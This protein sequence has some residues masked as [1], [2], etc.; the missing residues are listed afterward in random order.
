MESYRVTK[1]YVP[2]SGMSVAFR[3][4]R[5]DSHCKFIHG[6]ALGIEITFECRTLD[7]RNWV[8]DFGGLKEI[9]AWIQENFDHKTLVARDDPEYQW[10]EE[11][12]RRG[13]LDMVAV[14]KIGCEG[15]A[16]MIGTKVE[17]WLD[18]TPHRKRVW[19][20]SVRVYEHDGNSSTWITSGD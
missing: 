18:N 8:L 16:R 3:Q 20:H 11:A 15:F 9:K 19:L 14:D 12:H 1:R 17:E 2:D 7:E 10:F 5:A 6:Y 13:I 4:W